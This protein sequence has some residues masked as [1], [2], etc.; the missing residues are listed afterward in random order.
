MPCGYGSKNDMQDWNEGKKVSIKFYDTKFARKAEQFN[1]KH[2]LPLYF[3]E[4][5]GEKSHVRI[6]DLGAG[7]FSIIGNLWFNG[8]DQVSV[9]VVASDLLADEYDE[10]RKKHHV[11]PVVNVEKQ[12]M[13]DLTYPDASFDIVHCTNA[14]D[15]CS[16]PIAAILEMRRICKPGGWIYLRHYTDVAEDQK[17]IGLHQ[18]NL[19]LSGMYDCRIWNEECDWKLTQILSGSKTVLGREYGYE[20]KN[21]VITTFYKSI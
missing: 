10:I 2:Y 12:N 6:A 11:I 5:I 1:F 7:L 19:S 8:K 17:H 21:M 18:W 15:H 9:D 16:D 3:E 13:E 14:L 4:M 20:P